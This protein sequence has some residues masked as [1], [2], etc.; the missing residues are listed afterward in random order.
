M[1]F[2]QLPAPIGAALR[3]ALATLGTY[4]AA[5]DIVPQTAWDQIAA[6]LVT[7]ATVAY[8]L[9]ATKTMAIE[10]DE[11]KQQLWQMRVDETLDLD[12]HLARF[13]YNLGELS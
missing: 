2:T 5:A 12:R 3:Y 1:T 9:V 11:A 8:G 13:T 4:L 6:A 7:I 10:A